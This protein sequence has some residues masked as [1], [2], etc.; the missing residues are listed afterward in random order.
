MLDVREI[1][2]HQSLVTSLDGAGLSWTVQADNV[3]RFRPTES[4][5]VQVVRLRLP[6]PPL[7]FRSVSPISRLLCPNSAHPDRG[8]A[9]HRAR[10]GARC[11]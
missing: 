4:S 7:F 8:A 11:A 1:T 9:L 2:C 3:A 6:P 10:S 5:C